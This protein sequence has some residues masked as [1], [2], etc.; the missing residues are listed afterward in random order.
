MVAASSAGLTSRRETRETALPSAVSL[1]ARGLCAWS[2]SPTFRSDI[3]P[4]QAAVPSPPD[5]A[6]TSWASRP[7]KVAASRWVRE[8]GASVGCR[9][10]VRVVGA[11]GGCGGHRDRQGRTC[12]GQA[13]SRSFC[14]GCCWSF[15]EQRSTASSITGTTGLLTLNAHVA[16]PHQAVAAAHPLLPLPIARRSTT[17]SAPTCPTSTPSATASP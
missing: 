15:S 14:R 1:G 16:C 3:S 5:L 12:R 17:T 4:A 6:W 10:W 2:A 9:G 13:R 7:T 8:L 11:G